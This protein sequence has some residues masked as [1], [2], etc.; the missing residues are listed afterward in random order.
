[1]KQSI[2]TIKRTLTVGLFSLLTV[3]AVY[4]ASAAYDIAQEP[5][6]LG[7]YVPP[8]NM[9][10]M[11]RDHKLYYEAY[12]DASDLNGDGV[13]DVGYKPDEIDY[14]GYFD[15][16]TCYSYTG[17]VFRPSADAIDKKCSGAWSGDFLNYLTT[18]RI[19]ALRKVLYGGKRSTDS[20][21][22]TILERTHIPQDAHSWGK[23]YDPATAGYDISDYA[24][25]ANPSSGRR[26]LFANTTLRGD[27]AQR[28]LLRIV[29]NSNARIW[30]WVSKE[31]PVA[32]SQIDTVGT[33]YPTDYTV[34]VEVCD[35]SYLEDN[36][37]QYPNGQWKPIGI[38]Q[39]Y[40]ENDRMLFGLLSGSYTK[41]TSGGVLRKRVSSITDEI[42][43]N[44]GQFT[45]T[46]G[47]I[48]AINRLQT[49]GFGTDYTYNS[50]CGWITTR[51]INDGECR[52]WGNPIA[53]MMYEGMRYFAGKGSPTGAFN[54]SSSGNDDAS[55]GLPLPGWNDPY[56]VYPS[57]SRPVQMVISDVNPSYDTDQLPGSSFS[58]F[59]GDISGLDAST[60]ADLIW[61]EEHGG[62][63]KHFIGESGGVSDGAP[64]AKDVSGF[65]D[66]RGLSPEEPTKQG[67]YYSAAVSHYGYTNDLNS[68]SG[69]QSMSTYAIALASPLPE[70][71]INVGG[72][73]VTLVPF[74]KSVGGSAFGSTISSLPNA[75]QPTNTIVDFYVDSITP[76]SGEFRVNFEDVEQGA[77]HDMD[78]IVTYR[79]EVQDAGGNLVADPANG[80]QLELSLSSDYAAGSIIQHM[81][82]VISGTSAD[83]VYLEVR[84]AD[85]T[86]G[87]DPDYY[88][89]TPNTSAELPL[90]ATRVFTPSGA[91]SATLLKNPL[92]YAA[93]WGRFDDENNNG[94]PDAQEEWDADS[95]GE[96]DNYFLVTNALTLSQQLQKAFNEILLESTS[97]A[98]IATNSTRLDTDTLIYQA[99]FNSE[100]WSG[101]LLAFAVNPDG[102]VGAQ[103]W[104]AAAELGSP[105]ARNILTWDPDKAVDGSG[106]PF[107]W[108]AGIS[109]SQKTYLDTNIGG[110][111]DGMG[112]DRLNYLRG[113]DSKERDKAGGV[114]RI[115]PHGLGDIVNS[116]P[117][118]VGNT[119]DYGFRTLP[120]E[121]EALAYTAYRES[122]TYLNRDPM[123]YVGGNDGMLHAFDA[124]T[125]EEKF[126]FVPNAVFPKLSWLTSPEYSHQYYVDG[127]PRAS[128]AYVNGAWGTFLVGSAGAGARS[129]FALDVSDPS[130]FTAT[131]VLWEFDAADSAD[132]GYVMGQPTIARLASGDW[133]VLVGNGVNSGDQLAKLL[134]IDLETGEL[135]KSI[136]TEVGGAAT[137]NGLSAPVPVD[138]NGDRVTD[139]VYAGDLQG[140][141]WKFDLTG[142][143]PSQWA[144]AFKGTGNKPAPLFTARS[145]DNRVQSITARPNVGRHP[146]GGIMVYFGTG[147]YFETTDNAVP[148]DPVIESFYGVWDKDAVIAG[149]NQLQQQTIDYQLEAEDTG[150]DFDTRIVSNNTV[151]YTTKSGWYIDLVPPTGTAE[152]ER[153]IDGALLRFGRIIFTTVIPS[154]NVCDFGGRS[155]LM[156]LDAVNGAR[157]TYAVFDANGDG[158][159]DEND[160]ITLS[161]GTQVPAS[162]KGSDE[163]ISTPG[164]VSA[165]GSEG[166]NLEYKY[167]SGSS[168]VIDVTV[169][170]GGGEYFGRQSWKQDP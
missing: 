78:A 69:D 156:E 6:F 104:D 14:Y 151:D 134:V 141:L 138:I 31:R 145:A 37:R 58:S 122:A 117:W 155:W 56:A 80:K 38:L 7:G 136:D 8:L 148:A 84:D 119:Q 165:G 170:Q 22:E 2:A 146:D 15:S 9:L 101:Q 105:S 49:V 17:G 46:V 167:T 19:D 21:A 85:T 123:V 94:I 62:T 25:L 81:G 112:E 124:Q 157:L 73:V 163:L 129:V 11:G 47:V 115:R 91:P 23:E 54:I 63:S 16:N 61:D 90:S 43:P 55:L 99:R 34:R 79:Y 116:D 95:D 147:K 120:D 100:T 92:W 164:I 140:N 82:Y 45:S 4:P 150:F 98:A 111:N 161:D 158:V 83:G 133:V 142:S 35:S 10:V 86:A 1:M 27:S 44:T 113:D 57:C 166:S 118:F 42:D 36:C 75:F 127:S 153:V 128:D 59:S 68:A 5:L 126:A 110:V 18:A 48:G 26:H 135:L 29:Q 65:S 60:I 125:G 93:K 87:S 154:Q 50:N 96:P 130:S 40:G 32:G 114:F 74:A 70:F 51:S 102:S 106:V 76:T 103:Q 109:A 64:T 30:N 108:N 77:D 169:E 67:G 139:Y 20:T 28:P 159:V 53:E 162:G 107:A 13:L 160:F 89:D 132:L 39:E 52:M 24:P 66:I 137:P 97:S 88:L 12:N 71:K 33:V 152:G 144:V 41:N 149:R 3:I 143:G 168:G 121:D 131:D 72:N